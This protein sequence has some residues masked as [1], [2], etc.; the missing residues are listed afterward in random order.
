MKS[1][2]TRDILI[3]LGCLAVQILLFRH[4]TIFGAE[5]DFVLVYLLW[6]MS[7]RDRTTAIVHGAALGFAMDFFLDFWGLHMLSKTLLAF[8]GYNFIPK[9][10]ETKMLYSQVFVI[11]LLAGL[12]HNLIFT[13]V[14]QF[15]EIFRV[16]QL[17]WVIWLGNS[18]L[19][20]LIGTFFYLFKTH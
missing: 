6:I 20:A 18:L 2:L 3:G 10:S 15:A 8:L 5:P 12:F 1:Q 19:T 14:A 11:I 13:G 17:F 4:L 16:D 9:V 7:S